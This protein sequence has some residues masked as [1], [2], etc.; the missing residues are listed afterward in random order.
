[1]NNKKSYSTRIIIITIITSFIF[2]LSITIYYTST[3][4]FRK[5]YEI[6]ENNRTIENIDHTNDTIKE[7]LNQLGLKLTDWASWDDTYKF[8]K[9]KNKSYIDSNLGNNSIA[10]IEVNSMVFVNSGNQIIYRKTINL[11]SKEELSSESIEE[12]ILTHNFLVKMQNSNSSSQGI[13]LLPEGPMLV[14]A[15]PI[16]NSDGQGPSR[17]TLIFGKLLDINLVN[18]ISKLT[19]LSISTYN[20]NDIFLPTDVANAKIKLSKNSKTITYPISESIKAGYTIL[21]DIYN[22][23]VLIMKVESSREIYQQG[24]ITLKSFQFI[25]ISAILLFGICI[26]L[27]IDVLFIFR[28]SKLNKEVQNIGD[29]KDFK[30]RV[31]EGRQDDIGFLARNINETLDKLSSVQ[32][33]EDNHHKELEITELK[34][35]DKLLELEKMNNLMVGR[36]LQMLELK[37]EIGEFKKSN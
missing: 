23:P 7:T 27:F 37:K 18:K 14:V 20:Y 5:S 29:K 4:L 32:T 13:I 10:S 28:F 25:S 15:S 1:M 3:N 8:I 2:I 31:T 35:R 12:H 34:M 11:N 17:G 36:E 19:H 21:Y 33:L 16:L 22:E 26:Y 9:D 30:I 6:I 24:L